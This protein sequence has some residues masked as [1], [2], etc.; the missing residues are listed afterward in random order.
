MNKEYKIIARKML[1]YTPKK[2]K[3]TPSRQWRQN[4]NLRRF[5]TNLHIDSNSTKK[6]SFFH[7]NSTLI[8]PGSLNKTTII[9]TTKLNLHTPLSKQFANMHRA[10]S[11][12]EL[13]QN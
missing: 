5:P 4:M 3:K 10:L 1:P 8:Q 2:K 11:S 6:Y 9:S 7:N 12:L 13:R